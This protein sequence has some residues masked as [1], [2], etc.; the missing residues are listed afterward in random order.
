MMTENG[1]FNSDLIT[2]REWPDNINLRVVVYIGLGLHEKKLLTIHCPIRKKLSNVKQNGKTC[3]SVIIT[4]T[5]NV[6]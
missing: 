1:P 2:G 3:R 6:C 4:V 5:F